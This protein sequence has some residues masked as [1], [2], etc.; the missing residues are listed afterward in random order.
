MLVGS[1]DKKSNNRAAYVFLRLNGVWVEA[2]KIESQGDLAFSSKVAI[3]GTNVVVLRI[4]ML[5]SMKLWKEHLMSGAYQLS[6][7]D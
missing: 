4:I 5:T 7:M 2:E 1:F 3:S 6:L